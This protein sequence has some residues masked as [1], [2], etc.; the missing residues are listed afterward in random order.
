MFEHRVHCGLVDD[1]EVDVVGEGDAAPCGITRSPHEQLPDRHVP[2][3]HHLAREGA[4]ASA[5]EVGI[6]TRSLVVGDG[7]EAPGREKERR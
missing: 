3:K 2:V 1:A 4:I 5:F 6:V 7:G